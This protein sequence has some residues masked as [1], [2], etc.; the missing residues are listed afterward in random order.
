MNRMIVNTLKSHCL[1]DYAKTIGKQNELAEVLFNNYF[2]H[3]KRI[4]KFS[5][6]REATEA[7]NIDWSAASNHMTNDDVVQHV[8]QEA[9]AARESGIHSVPHY[10]IYL[11]SNPENVIQFSG[12]QP[13]ATMLSVI[14]KVL[15]FK[16]A[17]V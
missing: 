15:A 4:D 9:A 5:V 14:K 11:K 13:A 6:L 3:A 1:L 10:Q 17:K 8:K 16:K 2:R 12:A 7:C